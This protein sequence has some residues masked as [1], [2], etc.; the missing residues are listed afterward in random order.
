[1]LGWWDGVFVVVVGSTQLCGYTNFKNIVSKLYTLGFSAA[2][3]DG[4]P[5]EFL[6]CKPTLARSVITVPGWE[7][8]CQNQFQHLHKLV[9]IPLVKVWSKM[10]FTSFFYIIGTALVFIWLYYNKR[11]VL[12]YFKQFNIDCYLFCLHSVLYILL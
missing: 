8:T 9:L 12:V 5:F 3:E 10:K 4:L 11:V 7:R 6:A 1:M 2:K